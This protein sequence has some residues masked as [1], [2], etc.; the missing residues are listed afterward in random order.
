MS[1]H[2]CPNG[3]TSESGDYCDTCGAPIAAGAAPAGSAGVAASAVPVGGPVVGGG[4]L[5]SGGRTTGSGASAASPAGP[6]PATKP[7]P[8]CSTDNADDALFCESCGYDFT[9]GTPPRAPDAPS[10]LDLDADGDAG[11]GAD[12]DAHAG[13]GAGPG[14]DINAGQAQALSP[15]PP[16]LAPAIEPG[17]VVEVWVDPD[18]HEAQES[19]VAC[20]SPGL[21]VVV[22]LTARSVLVGRRSVSRGINPEVDCG[23]DIGV[24]RRHAQLSTDGQ[25]W[26]VEDLQSAN[27]TYVGPASGPLPTTALPAGRREL[28]GDDRVYVGAWT[29]LVLREATPQERSGTA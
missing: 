12:A 18:W 26:W 8:H 15:A 27:G 24:S 16:P 28:D 23:A 10:S 17:Y 25:R 3:H 29:R 7:C 9:T 20:P 2:I 13:A 21:P 14:A 22:P 5:G 19:E 4:S 1:G 6:L 11:S